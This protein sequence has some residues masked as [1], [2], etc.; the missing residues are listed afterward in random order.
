M[1]TVLDNFVAIFRTIKL[2]IY[3]D[4]LCLSAVGSGIGPGLFSS[5]MIM[6]KLAV[7]TVLASF[8]R[9]ECRA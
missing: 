1:L 9:L 8:I 5:G 2:K 3:I 4:D 6:G 7:I